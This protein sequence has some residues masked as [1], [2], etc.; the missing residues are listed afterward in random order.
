M[1]KNIRTHTEHIMPT[2]EQRRNTTK[3]KENTTT[4]ENITGTHI[5]QTKKQRIRNTHRRTQKQ[6]QEHTQYT[7]MNI[8]TEEQRRHN[9]E[10]R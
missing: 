10:Q 1:H 4:Q 9:Y 7:W 3:H 2:Q 6:T 8:N 5:M